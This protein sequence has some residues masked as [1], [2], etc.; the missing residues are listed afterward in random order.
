M[1]Q[2]ISGKLK[3]AAQRGHFNLAKLARR[4]NR[5]GSSRFK[6]SH[7]Q[8]GRSHRLTERSLVLRQTHQK[9]SGRFRPQ[10]D[11]FA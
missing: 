8:S 5:R 11:I 9:L 3:H 6:E 4:Q 2:T 10:H 7:I 1:P